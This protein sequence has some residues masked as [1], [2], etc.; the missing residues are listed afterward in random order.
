MDIVCN[1]I[2][3]WIHNETLVLQERRRQVHLRRPAEEPLLHFVISPTACRIHHRQALDDHLDTFRQF[4]DMGNTALVL[5]AHHHTLI[6]THWRLS[7]PQG[8]ERDTQRIEI[9]G[10][11]NLHHSVDHIGIHLRSC[12]D[13]STGLGCLMR[14]AVLI[15]Q[16]RY[17]EVSQYQF[18]MFLVTEEEVAWLH[19]LVQD[20][21]L[22]T[23]SQCG[24]SLQRDAPELVDITVKPVLR[25]RTAS[26]IFHQFVKT[27]LALHV[28]LS[29]VEHFDDHLKAKRVDD[30]EYLLVDIKVGIIY[31]QHIVL[32]VILDQ[33]HLCLTGIVAKDTHIPIAD[34]FQDKRILSNL[35]AIRRY[36]TCP[37]RTFH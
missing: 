10:G 35:S 4:V 9:G 28:G 29:I 3:V 24:S 33:E 23:I 16:G 21:A 30:L 2:A 25:Q 1:Q 31:L 8:H 7:K 19:I 37:C 13:G 27:V 11:R 15:Q 32:A 12:I 14:L 20:I 34:T 17:A 22:M 18:R 6:R 26:Q 5:L 36:T